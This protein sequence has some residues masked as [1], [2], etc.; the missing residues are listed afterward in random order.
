MVSE[1]RPSI[2]R[3]RQSNHPDNVSPEFADSG[4]FNKAIKSFRGTAALGCA[5]VAYLALKARK[6]EQIAL[7]LEKEQINNLQTLSS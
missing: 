4:S 3:E 1:L 6:R 2:A 5:A 7:L